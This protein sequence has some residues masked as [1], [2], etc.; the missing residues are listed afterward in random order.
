[1]RILALKEQN[2]KGDC[3]EPGVMLNKEDPFFELDCFHP[4]VHI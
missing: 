3:G 4:A 2:V 1:M